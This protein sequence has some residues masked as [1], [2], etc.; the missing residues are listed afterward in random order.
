MISFSLVCCCLPKL[1][2]KAADQEMS[3]VTL[4]QKLHCKIVPN[5]EAFWVE[6]KMLQHFSI[7]LTFEPKLFPDPFL[8]NTPKN[9]T[10]QL[11][12]QGFLLKK[13]HTLKSMEDN[14]TS[15]LHKNS[16]TPPKKSYTSHFCYRRSM[17][18]SHENSLP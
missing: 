17:I 4:S 3:V 11:H 10:E 5:T 2:T 7:P 13:Q 16:E 1:Q 18:N 9:F 6:T 14:A 15:T 12:H 8:P